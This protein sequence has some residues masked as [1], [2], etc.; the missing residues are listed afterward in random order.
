[1]LH[2]D[3][4]LRKTYFRFTENWEWNGKSSFH[5][6]NDP[7]QTAEAALEWYRRQL[8]NVNTSWLKF[9]INT[10]EFL[11]GINPSIVYTDLNFNIQHLLSCLPSMPCTKTYMEVGDVLS[12]QRFGDRQLAWDWV[13]DENASWWLVSPR[14]RHTVTQHPVVV[15]VR[16][17]LPHN[18]GQEEER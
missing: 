15:P 3:K 4:F 16:P 5:R 12:V 11:L 10:M 18:I 17:Y 14:A 7:K 9:W 1:M 8:L 13:D 6:N 2:V